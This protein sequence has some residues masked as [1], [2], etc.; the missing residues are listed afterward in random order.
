MYEHMRL[1]TRDEEQVVAESRWP[2]NPLLIKG[3]VQ[4]SMGSPPPVYNGGL[5]R[6]EVR[7]FD[8]EQRRPGLPADVA[9]LVD[10]IA[11]ERVGIQLVNLSGSA[12]RKV[13][14]QAGAF[15]EHHFGQ[16]SFREES[17]EGLERHAGLW[18]REERA[19]EDRQV[20]VDG[21]HF[22]VELP[23]STSMSLSCGLRRFT[24]DPSCLLPWA[25][26]AR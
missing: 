13:V 2:P 19:W 7:Y 4:V 16:V 14:V 18:L 20:M 17:R 1:D 6:A 15:A 25:A 5:L 23:P 11:A 21:R 3:L 12:T 9:A 22:V 26:G 24:H 8:E 10:E